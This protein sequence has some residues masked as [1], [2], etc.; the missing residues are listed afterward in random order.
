MTHTTFCL[1]AHPQ[2]YA[3]LSS[4]EALAV[5]GLL[6]QGDEHEIVTT[7][8]N[9]TIPLA[10]I[11]EIPVSQQSASLSLTHSPRVIDHDLRH[12]DSVFRAVPQVI[13][14]FDS[15]STV[16]SSPL[17]SYA[18]TVPLSVVNRALHVAFTAAQGPI[19]VSVMFDRGIETTPAPIKTL[20]LVNKMGIFALQHT[21]YDSELV[22][23]FSTD[24]PVILRLPSASELLLLRNNSLSASP[25]E[26]VRPVIELYQPPPLSPSVLVAATRRLYEAL[27]LLS[28]PA[29]IKTLS[30]VNKMGIFRTSPHILYVSKLVPT[31]TMDIPAILRLPPALELLIPCNS[32]ASPVESRKH[33]GASLHPA[34]ELQLYQ[35]PPLH[36][37][38]LAAVARRLYEALAI[39]YPV[40]AIPGNDNV[41]ALLCS[42]LPDPPVADVVSK[43]LAVSIAPSAPSA[44]SSAP[45]P[46]S[47]T[48]NT[49]SDEGPRLALKIITNNPITNPAAPQDS[50]LSKP[51]PSELNVN[52]FTTGSCAPTTSEREKRRVTPVGGFAGALAAVQ[53]QRAPQLP[54]LPHRQRSTNTYHVHDPH[55]ARR[56]TS[57]PR[58]FQA[59]STLPPRAREHQSTA[60]REAPPLDRSRQES[61]RERY[62]GRG[63]WE[64]GLSVQD[65][66]EHTSFSTNMRSERERIQSRN[67]Y[68]R[69]VSAAKK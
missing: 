46:P 32:G 55:L 47:S 67:E 14:G 6:Q 44:L 29:P 41:V 43:Y 38:V 12:N 5:V 9:G 19:D 35:P 13:Q 54:P 37:S 62:V 69:R 3:M 57:Y 56:S 63:K 53:N 58:D 36:P 33:D 39:R 4:V 61:S 10:S 15:L 2:S 60:R 50:M 8:R 49:I 64:R 66:G 27:A 26:S 24:I 22:P 1:F 51:P 59:P 31:F 11:I 28:T 7:E 18:I 68:L 42:P 16:N 52:T 25:V 48:N 34:M 21:F 23:A 40:T 17:I 30:I 20:S 45:V 65:L